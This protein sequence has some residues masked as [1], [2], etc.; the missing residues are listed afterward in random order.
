MT[1]TSEHPARIERAIALFEAGEWDALADLPGAETFDDDDAESLAAAT[2]GED[3]AE[4]WHDWADADDRGEALS[5]IGC[6]LWSIEHDA[7]AVVVLERA[8]ALGQ[9][10]AANIGELYV[11]LGDWPSAERW[12]RL[13]LDAKAHWWERAAYRLGEHAFEVDDQVGDDVIALLEAG[14]TAAKEAV[15]V[16]GWLYRRRGDIDAARRILEEAHPDNDLVALPLGNL[17]RDE[18]DDV[19]GAR[20]AYEAGYKGGDANSAF[21][22]AVML[23]DL[24]HPEEALEWMRKAAR[25]GDAAARADLT[26]RGDEGWADHDEAGDPAWMRALYRGDLLPHLQGAALPGDYPTI[27]RI[28][29]IVSTPAPGQI[30]HAARLGWPIVIEPHARGFDLAALGTAITAIR[31]LT[32]ADAAGIRGWSV[33]SDAR[34]LEELEMDGSEPNEP[35]DLS[36]LPRLV[37]ASVRGRNAFSA[38]GNPAVRALSMTL[39]DGQPAPDVQA[40][41]EFFGVSGNAAGEAIASIVQPES[42]VQLVVIGAVGLDCASLLRFPSLRDVELRACTGVTNTRMLERI[43]RLDSLHVDDCRDVEDVAFVAGFVAR[44]ERAGEQPADD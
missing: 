11:Y 2:G 44:L 19:E 4:Y 14:M 28:N 7:D 27:F 8:Q 29:D 22:L 17:L 38:A 25:G 5:A 30:A 16:L 18:F 42:L 33:L 1:N 6:V 36:V 35:V 31:D 40:P 34:S 21:N 26:S 23:E 3:S 15:V 12:F 13:A 24:D 20:A 39:L 32:I 41:I 37:D 43:P 9:D 10:C